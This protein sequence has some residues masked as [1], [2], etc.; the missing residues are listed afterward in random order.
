MAATISKSPL[1]KLLETVAGILVIGGASG[2]L[3]ELLGW[4]QLLGFFRFLAPDGYEVIVYVLL[5]ALGTTVG[6]GGAKLTG[7]PRG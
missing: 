2:L 5:I 6:A 4:Y 7:R 1:T 3:H